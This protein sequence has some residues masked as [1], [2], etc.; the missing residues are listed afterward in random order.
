MIYIETREGE[1]K[2]WNLVIDM[3]KSISKPVPR[4]FGNEDEALAF[5][6]YLKK[7]VKLIAENIR[8]VEQ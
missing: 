2:E 8:I 3:K 4:E 5:A 7:E 1:D 6:E